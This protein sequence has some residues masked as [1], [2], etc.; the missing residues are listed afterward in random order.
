MSKTSHESRIQRL[1]RDERGNVSIIFGLSLVPVIALVGAGIDLSRL[2]DTKSKLQTAVDATALALTKGLKPTS[3]AGDSL[4]TRASVKLAAYMPGKTVT[5]TQNPTLT[6]NNGQLCLSASTSVDATLT[7]IFNRNASTVNASSCAVI[8]S[9]GPFEIALVMDNTGSMGTATTEGPTKL[10]AA[11]TAA[12]ALVAQLN[13][14]GQTPTAS[15]SVVPFS[16][17]VNVGTE[18][19]AMP[20]MDTSGQSSLHWQNYTRPATATGLP[21]S[22]FD[23]FTQTGTTWAGCIEERADPYLIT[24]TAASSGTPDTLFV[25]YL[26]P[27]EGDLSSSDLGDLPGASIGS[28]RNTYTYSSTTYTNTDTGQNNYLYDFGG[29]CT[30]SATD[31]YYVADLANAISLGSGA[32]KLCKYKA[33]SGV[34]SGISSSVSSQGPNHN[35][36]ANKLLPLTQNATNI[37]AK[38]DSMSAGGDTNLLPG[39]MWGWRTISPN[40]PF[41]DTT[42][43]ATAPTGTITPKSY[44]EPKNT[45]IIILMTDGDNN[46]TSQSSYNF[47]SEYNSLGYYVNNRLS[48]YG[49]TAY[50]VPTG[51]DYS[52]N[53][54]GNTTSSNWHPQMDAALLAACTNAK[55]A[56]VVIFTVG[57][58]ISVAEISNEGLKTL[59]QCASSADKAFVSTGATEITN[60][61]KQIGVGLSNLRIKS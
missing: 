17:S 45:K 39:F 49:G 20:W 3:T 13:V 27:D 50:P 34:L 7:G 26:W 25:P 46:W 59:Q 43:L 24:D 58:S 10:A 9:G 6:N 40:G 54:N 48:A 41:A 47:K 8:A 29:I 35:C 42:T 11:K 61:F 36:I 33:S 16:T 51:G 60:A 31:K 5:L 44:T 32:T 53:Y 2:N 55:N 19:A 38:I 1:L 22:R 56:G 28:G 18:Y 37:N 23:L 52:G 57:F 15:F 14:T 21:T 4:N 12:K 30:S